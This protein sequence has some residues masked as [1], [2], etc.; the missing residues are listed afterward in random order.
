MSQLIL[1]CYVLYEFQTLSVLL[2]ITKA[3]TLCTKKLK[4]MYA[5]MH[6]KMAKYALK[7]ARKFRNIL[8]L[9]QKLNGFEREFFYI[10]IFRAKKFS[11]QIFF[12]KF[13]LFKRRNIKT[14]FLILLFNI[15]KNKLD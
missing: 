1:Y 9:S 11:R 10:K 12:K 14:V 8:R 5:N 2:D 7:Y 6:E 3:G 15:L 13:C 4:N